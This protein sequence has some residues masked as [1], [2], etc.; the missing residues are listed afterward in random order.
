MLKKNE[1]KEGNGWDGL[2]RAGTAA[3]PL[4]SRLQRCASPDLPPATLAPTL[5]P[6]SVLSSLPFTTLE[7]IKTLIC[8]LL[9]F[10]FL[11]VA[12][13]TRHRGLR[14][15][16]K[17]TRPPRFVFCTFLSSPLCFQHVLTHYLVYDVR[18]SFSKGNRWRRHLASLCALTPLKKVRAQIC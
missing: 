16:Y 11:F 13:F 7:L 8:F 4:F 1:K 3:L 5:P 17:L 6:H 10:H 12:S 15:L 14:W 9:H 2:S 18:I